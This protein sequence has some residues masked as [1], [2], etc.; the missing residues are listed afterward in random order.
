MPELLL[1]IGT[2]KTGTTSIQR[3]CG[4]NRDALREHG[5]WYPSASVGPFPKHYAHHRIAH[6]IAGN[7]DKF[8]VSSA[9]EFFA[10]VEKNMKAGERALLSAEPLYRH[11]L[12]DPARASSGKPNEAERREQFQRYA[13]VVRDCLSDFDVTVMVMLRRQ[14]LFV[15]SLYAEQVLATAYERPIERF[16]QERDHLLNYAERLD[17]WAEAFGAERISVRT[18]EPATF[19]HPIER[20]FVEWLGLDWDESFA[21]G[22]KHNVTPS[23]TFVEFKRMMNTTGHGGDVNTVYRKWVEQVGERVGTDGAP[24]L[25]KYYLQPRDRVELLDR[26]ADGNRQVAERFCGRTQLF[27]EGPEREL[28]RYVDRPSL[29]DDQFRAIARELFRMIAEDVTASA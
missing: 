9:R 12:P 26:F 23:R 8:D 2:H 7:D 6:A 13:Q 1:H 22:S 21:I 15:E 10:A 29:G 14:D 19:V 17:I 3:F 28:A 16:M 25:G 24:D 27:S 11:M 18:F 20:T 5:V 4:N